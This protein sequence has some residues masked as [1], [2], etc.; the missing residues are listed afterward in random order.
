VDAGKDW[1]EH[2]LKMAEM[3]RQQEKEA[4]LLK[5]T[6]SSTPDVDLV[7]VPEDVTVVVE[8]L[9]DLDRKSE[10]KIDEV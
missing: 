4:A 6:Q 5:A 1:I 7:E 2:Y 3:M 10:K 9:D 8:D